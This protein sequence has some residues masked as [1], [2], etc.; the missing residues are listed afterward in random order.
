ME[1]H[2]AEGGLGEAVVSALAEAGAPLARFRKLAVNG[3]PHSGKSE[4]LLDTFGISS[5]NIVAAVRALE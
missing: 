5:K 2:Y 4:E 1:D 3:L